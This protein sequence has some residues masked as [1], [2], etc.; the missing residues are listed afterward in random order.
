MNTRR[1]LEKVRSLVSQ[2][3]QDERD[4]ERVSLVSPDSLLFYYGN[5][6]SQVG[7]DGILAEIFRRIGVRKSTYVEFGAWDGIYLS[8][9]R[10]LY[11]QGW[12]GVLIEADAKRF[13][14]IRSRYGKNCTLINAM[15]GAP[16]QGVEGRPL[17]ALLKDSSISLD[18]VSFVSIDVDGPDLE[19]F[20]E[21]GFSPAVVLVEGGTDIA[22]SYPLRLPNETAWANIHQPLRVVFE[23]ASKRGYVPVCLYQDTYFVRGDL[24]S[25]FAS[26]EPETLYS[27]F[28][29]FL[30]NHDRA[31]LMNHRASTAAI[32]ALEQSHFGKFYADPLLYHTK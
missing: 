7:Q 32:V 26:L 14:K 9:G 5:I 24:A 20:D 3:Y 23:V 6:Y 10:F 12:H 11:E 31:A 21:L 2:R 16:K 27:D 17:D 13:G 30:T 29:N 4:P 28:F 18:A 22:P 19:I 8:N 25:K 1:L 15:V